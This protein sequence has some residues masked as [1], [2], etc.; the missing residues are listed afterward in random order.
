MPRPSAHQADTVRIIGG[1]WRSRKLHFTDVPGLRPTPD[2]VRETLFNWLQS[3]V[4]GANCIDLF[5]G[6]GALGFEALSR[7]ASQCLFVDSHRQCIEDIKHNLEQFN[8]S[9]GYT[10]LN[11]ALQ[12]LKASPSQFSPRR[13]DI[14]FI[15]PPY[16]TDFA[17]PCCHLL[18]DQEWLSDN[19]MIY[20]ESASAIEEAQL[21]E[22]WRL[23]RQKKTGQVNYHLA[24]QQKSTPA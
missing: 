7:G 14:A 23:H 4:V 12:L 20:I 24:V 22:H 15:D 9:G 21:P 5:A 16:A 3:E 18:A 13:F 11:D 1:Q 8:A 2:R 17:L 6:S 19:A 10:S